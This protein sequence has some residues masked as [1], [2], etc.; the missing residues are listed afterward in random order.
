M[1]MRDWTLRILKLTGFALV[2]T[3]TFMLVTSLLR[4]SLQPPVLRLYLAI[5]FVHALIISALCWQM[6]PLLG[7]WTESFPLLLRWTVLLS[8]LGAAAVA[9]SAVAS[10]IVHYTIA[11]MHDVPIGAIF[12]EG[13][14]VAIP[15]TLVA[16]TITTV[17]VA[18]R[19][20]LEVN[21]AILQEQ[22]LKRETAE[23][24]AA[25]A[26]LASLS[27]RVQPHFLF[28]TLNSIA[29]LIR[30]NPVEAEHTIE[31]LAALLRSSLDTAGTIPLE[32]ELMLVRDYLE[33]QKTRMDER[34][35]FT[36][37]T[38]PGLH[39][40]VPPFSVQT[41]VENS[42]KHAA[43]G[44]QVL[45]LLVRTSRYDSQVAISVIDN[46][47]GFD[48]AFVKPGHGLDMLGARL[49]AVFEDRA[50]IDYFREPKRMTVRLRVPRDESIPG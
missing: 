46:G 22:R 25:E 44:Q 32:Q 14:A 29:A 4:A 24:L 17:I 23:K 16:G 27:A 45:D 39:A 15:I 18:G 3:A 30:E 48:P 21:K 12:S 47:P 36:I 26:K 43:T 6:M 20:R 49:R 9:G 41:L 7:K 28:N 1:N 33:I 11:H 8:A 13:I 5:F 50:S 2:V 10:V 35:S 37:T 40:T 42:V 38:D 31:R 19:H 34:L